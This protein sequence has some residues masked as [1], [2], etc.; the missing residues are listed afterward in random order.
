MGLRYCSLDRCRP[1]IDA[2]GRV[3]RRLY[4]VGENGLRRPRTLERYALGDNKITAGAK[5]GPSACMISLNWLPLLSLDDLICVTWCSVSLSCHPFG[6][7]LTDNI[8][9]TPILGVGHSGDLGIQHRPSPGANRASLQHTDSIS[10]DN[11]TAI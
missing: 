9:T 6:N 8:R 2:L 3:R 5:A 7:D 1:V 10:R 4:R 11:K